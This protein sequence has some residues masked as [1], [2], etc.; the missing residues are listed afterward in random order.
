MVQSDN[1]LFALICISLMISYDK[2][3]FLCLLIVHLPQGSV[4]SALFCTTFSMGYLGY[5]LLLSFMTA[6]YLL[7]ITHLSGVW[8]VNI[9]SHSV[10][11]LLIW[12]I[13]F[14]QWGIFFDINGG[15]LGCKGYSKHCWNIS[16]IAHDHSWQY[17]VSQYGLEDVRLLKFCSIECLRT[18]VPTSL[19]SN[20]WSPL[21]S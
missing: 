11:C 7:D 18:P 14:S 5:F 8:C 19:K 21:W 12:V 3:L 15:V 1:L 13:V 16:R 2:Y 10:W 9:F 6:L 17:S 4:C 20:C